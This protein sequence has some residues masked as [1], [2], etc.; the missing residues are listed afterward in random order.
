MNLSEL[1][2]GWA[3]FRA[4]K[5]VADPAAWKQG[6]VTVN[7]VTAFL[8]ALLVLLKGTKYDPHMD[9]ATVAYIAG[10]LYG[11]LNWLFTVATTDKI[12]ILGQRS[13]PGAASAGLARAP[14]DAPAGGQGA[15]DPP[16]GSGPA[17]AR[18][19][20]PV[21]PVSRSAD[22]AQDDLRGGP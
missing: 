2:K 8:A 12:G 20:D 1:S 21:R 9:D 4:G 7:A 10:G 13:P 22:P 3:V 19:P 17:I 18:A 11:V 6:Q 16:M 14:G 15:L 5:T